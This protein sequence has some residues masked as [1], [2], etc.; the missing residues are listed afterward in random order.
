MC[1]LV[2]W[3]IAWLVK[4][5]WLVGWFTHLLFFLFPFTLL[6]S[7]KGLACLAKNLT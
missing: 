3:L 4:V 6:Q 5:G 1:F 2:S 7:L